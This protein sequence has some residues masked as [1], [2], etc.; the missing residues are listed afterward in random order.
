ME[1]DTQTGEV[2][3]APSR[4][5]GDTWGSVR[6][7]DYSVAQTADA[8]ASSKLWLPG[9]SK[10]LDLP[11]A[12]LGE[13]GS[14]GLVDRDITGPAPRGPFDK[15]TPSPTSTYPSL[16]NHNAKNET[17]IV[18]EPDSQLRARQGMEEKAD[19]VWATASRAHINRDFTFGSQALAVAFTERE[20]IGGRVWPNVTFGYTRFDYAFAA[21]GNCTLGLLSYWWHSS[22]QQSS[23]A[24]MTIRIR[25]V[26][27]GPRLPH[28]HR[29][30]AN[31]RRVD[32]RRVP[33]QRANARLP[34]RRRPKPRPPRPPRNLRPPQLRRDT[35]QAVRRL[36]AKWCAEP[37]V[38]GG[39]KRPAG[40]KLIV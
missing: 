36:S 31:H 15:T 7:S 13:A 16:W 26:P 39:K 8:L 4:S 37:S 1:G 24:G 35:Y 33:R 20:S 10:A 12:P 21:W 23:K 34:R 9:T 2:L 28:T 29:R 17:R 30:P 27:P 11:V 22:R 25:R 38:H 14:L 32:L 3:S 18:C 5:D 19:T 6:V 40:A